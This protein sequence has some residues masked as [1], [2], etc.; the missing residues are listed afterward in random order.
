VPALTIP[1]AHVLLWSQ[2]QC[3]LH[4]EPVADMLSENRQ[5]YADDRRMDYVPI[6]IGVEADCR[7]AADSV[8]ATMHARQDARRDHQ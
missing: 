1:T 5:A 3:A 2:S 7:L 4:I 6:Y 8:R